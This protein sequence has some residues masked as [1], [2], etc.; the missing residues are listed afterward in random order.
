MNKVLVFDWDRTLS[1]IYSAEILLSTF[2]RDVNPRDY[3]QIYRDRRKTTKTMELSYMMQL[4]EHCSGDYFGSPVTKTHMRE[5]GEKI[6]TY[7]GV[8]AL[9]ADLHRKGILIYVV[10]GGVVHLLESHPAAAFF[11]R[12]YGCSYHDEALTTIEEVV[13]A[14][15]KVKCIY[16]LSGGDLS[17]VVY[18]G[19][20]GSDFWA[21][22]AVRD[23]GGLAAGVWDPKVP[24]ALPQVARLQ[25]ELNLNFISQADYIQGGPLEQWITWA[26]APTEGYIHL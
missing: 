17:S 13:T 15:D 14:P 1:P 5:L 16:D 24:Q 6:P 12:I 22:K 3:W 9:L 2:R 21:M 8:M 23:N 18:I 7:P 10:T 19:D 20:G 26:T 25:S 11:D 4:S